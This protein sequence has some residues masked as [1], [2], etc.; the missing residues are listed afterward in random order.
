MKL[1][2]CEEP[3]TQEPIVIYIKVENNN[4]HQYFLDAGLGFWQ[5]WDEIDDDDDYNYIDRTNELEIFEKTISRIWCE[6]QQNNSQIIIQFENNE[7]LILRT[8][9]PKIF[10]SKSELILIK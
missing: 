5:N 8:V 1:I 2:V 3:E 9:Q 7:K 4:W 6:P 10:D